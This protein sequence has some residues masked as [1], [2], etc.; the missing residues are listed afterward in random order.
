MTNYTDLR[1]TDLYT[2][3]RD[4]LSHVASDRLH[5][6]ESMADTDTKRLA[7]SDEIASRVIDLPAR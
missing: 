4:V 3:L 1:K 7:V 6:F 2:D 5:V